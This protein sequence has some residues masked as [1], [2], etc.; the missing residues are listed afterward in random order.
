MGNRRDFGTPWTILAGP[1][2]TRSRV[3]GQTGDPRLFRSPFQRIQDRNPGRIRCSDRATRALSPFYVIQ[4]RTQRPSSSRSRRETVRQHHRAHP[5]R[6]RRRLHRETQQTSHQGPCRHHAEQ[7]RP[8]PRGIAGFRHVPPVR[9]ALPHEA[10]SISATPI[11]ELFH[12]AK[13][14]RLGPPINYL[15]HQTSGGQVVSLGLFG[16]SA[17]IP[18]KVVKEIEHLVDELN[19]GA[20]YPFRC[21]GGGFSGGVLKLALM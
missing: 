16:G 10:S 9:S 13:R 21:H 20:K 7:R 19:L 8:A 11:A 5:P 2:S 17:P 15:T 4:S 18:P 1:H 6:T 14:R 12:P 3:S